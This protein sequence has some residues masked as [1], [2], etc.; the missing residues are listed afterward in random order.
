MFEPL[1]WQ[2]KGQPVSSLFHIPTGFAHNSGLVD[3]LRGFPTDRE[4]VYRNW[5]ILSYL[6]LSTMGRKTWQNG[7]PHEQ[8]HAVCGDNLAKINVIY[9]FYARTNYST[10]RLTKWPSTIGIRFVTTSHS[11]P[12]RWFQEQGT[13]I[14]T[15]SWFRG[16]VTRFYHEITI[17]TTSCYF[18]TILL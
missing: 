4:T 1:L 12:V 8:N 10:V 13:H 16:I 3:G 2:K 6:S 11:L 17:L 18:N 5:P 14:M 7:D 9:H 15:V